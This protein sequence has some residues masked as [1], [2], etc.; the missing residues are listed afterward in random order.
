MNLPATPSRPHCYLCASR[1]NLTDDH[2]PPKGF[3]PPNDRRD[4]IKAPLCR[5]CHDPLKKT[6]EAMRVWLAAATGTSEAGKWIWK[7]KVLSS[8]FRRSPKL[9]AHIRERHLRP[10]RLNTATGEVGGAI[11]TMPQG[12]AIPF[13]RRLTKGLI[14]TFH[15]DYD[16]FADFFTVDY[17]LPTPDAVQIVGELVSHLPQLTVGNGVFRVWHGITADTGDA[18][19]FVYLFYDA[20][21]FVCFHG[22]SEVYQ[23]TFD[24]GYEEEPGLPKQL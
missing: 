15:P 11:L 1:E 2:L 5:P 16:Y 12:R 19:A 14:Y 8:T 20:V 21:C 24:E 6:D 22:K 23:Q 7:N 13:I 4:L 9:L 10:I 18:G 17:R 3:F